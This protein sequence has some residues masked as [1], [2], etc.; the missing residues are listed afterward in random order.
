MT[1]RQRKKKL[2]EMARGSGLSDAYTETLIRLK[3]QKGNKPLLGLKVLMWV[4]YSER[5]LQTEELCHAVGVE[6]G[7]TDPDLENIPLLRTLLSSCLGLVTVEASSSTVRLVHFTLQEHLL[8]DAGLLHTPHS[9]IAEVCLTYLNFGCIRDISPTVCSAFPEAPLLEYASHYWWEHAKIG[10]AENVKILALRLLDRFDQHISARLLSLD[11][12]QD[13]GWRSYPGWVEERFVGFT[14]LHAVVFLE[15]LELLTPVLKMKEWDVNAADCTGNT[16]L[17]RAARR[18][19]KEVVGVLLERVDV[20]PNKA[21]SKYGRTPLW[22]AAWVGHEE[23]V[24]A[25]LGREDLNPNQVD[26]TFGRTPLSQAAGKGHSEVVRILLGR[27]DV[28]PNKADTFYGQTPLKR[29]LENG[30]KRVVKMLLER[31]GV[32]PDHIAA[33]DGQTTLT[34]AVKNGQKGVAEVLIE[35]EDINPNQAVTI[36]GRALAAEEL[37]MLEEIYAAKQCGDDIA[38]SIPYPSPLWTLLWNYCLLKVKSIKVRCL[39]SVVC[40]YHHVGC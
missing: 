35:R 23:V 28:D 25:L 29:A 6:I 5:P 12:Y 36:E 24:G 31:E 13:T 7:S 19:Q 2:E 3:A 38:V 17:T 27:E 39:E 22:W 32:N 1:I 34:W 14:G 10:M 20:N 30:H 8:S 4:L 15:A 33:E 21:D 18:G 16:P 26:T 9:T 37:E 11:N 40:R